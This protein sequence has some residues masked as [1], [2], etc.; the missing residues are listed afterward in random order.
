MVIGAEANVS[1]RAERDWSR[2]TEAL[3]LAFTLD[4]PLLSG[5]AAPHQWSAT[6]R[7]P[8]RLFGGVAAAILALHFI[9]PKSL[10]PL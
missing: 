1:Q 4:N 8:N 3:L 7:P 6:S 2:I 5:G 9:R 10:Q